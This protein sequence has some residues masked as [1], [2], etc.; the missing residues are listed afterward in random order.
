MTYTSPRPDINYPLVASNLKSDTVKESILNIQDSYN[1]FQGGLFECYINNILNSSRSIG[2]S[3]TDQQDLYIMNVSMYDCK[4]YIDNWE[5]YQDITNF[6]MKASVLLRNLNNNIG[7]IFNFTFSIVQ[8]SASFEKNF[9]RVLFH[10]RF[11][12]Y[13]QRNFEDDFAEKL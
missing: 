1:V 13:A 2:N 3:I 9:E 10:N 11:G 12:K 6:E 8:N 5:S 7:G 4:Y